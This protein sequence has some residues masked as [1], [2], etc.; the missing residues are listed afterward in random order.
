MLVSSRVLLYTT[1][2]TDDKTSEIGSPTT[3]S[4]SYS[5]IKQ[6]T[7]KD[8]KANADRMVSQQFADVAGP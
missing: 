4:V 2:S 5:H 7:A 1:L 8:I 6:F 3:I